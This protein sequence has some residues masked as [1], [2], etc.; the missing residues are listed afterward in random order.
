MSDDARIP[1]ALG[2]YVVLRLLGSGAMGSVYLAEDP[3]LKRKVAIKVIRPDAAPTPEDRQEVLARFEREAEVSSLLNDPG[4]VTIYDLGDTEAGPFLAMEY[5]EGQSLEA[6]IR[7]GASA[8]LG[9]G[10]KLALLSTVARALD[11]AH[12]LG[13][14]HRDVKPANI[15]VTADLRAKLMDFGI[16]HRQ[17]AHLTRTGTFLGTP[18]YASPEQ[19]REAAVDGK[20]DLFSLGVVA[21]ELLSGQVPFPGT[22]LNTILFRIVNEPPVDVP[23]VDGILQDAWRRVFQKVLAKEPARRH[24]SC[25]AFL[26]DLQAAAQGDELEE[27]GSLTVLSRSLPGELSGTLSGTQP[28]AVPRRKH[29]W[30]WVALLVGVAAATAYVAWPRVQ[31]VPL[32]TRP[33][34]AEVLLEGRVIGQTPCTLRGLRG[35]EIRFQAPGFQVH[36]VRVPE[37]GAPEEV[38]LQPKVSSETLRTDPPGAQVE[39]D[40]VLLKGVTPL[41]VTWSQDRPHTVRFLHPAAGALTQVIPAGGTPE[42]RAVP[43]GTSGAPEAVVAPSETGGVR[44]TGA[45]PVRVKV[46]GQDQGERRPPFQL[47]LPAGEHTLEWSAPKV[48]FHR[49]DRISLRPG[50]TTPVALPALHRLEVETFPTDGPVLI[51]GQPAGIT[52][53]G[54]SSVPVAAGPH[55]ISIQGRPS[56]EKVDLASDRRVRFR[57]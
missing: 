26:E 48:F 16:A 49:T 36:T 6:L 19:I 17:D 41:E 15:M 50:Q 40:G 57:Y 8:G 33:A 5:V 34:G 20:S 47:S 25:T 51:D 21:F 23:P 4:V 11:H 45:F 12:R 39:L 22:S 55:V 35:R 9:L 13:V 43:L 52:S 46:D 38:Q 24:A 37:R 42:S 56:R 27:L 53:D 54:L 29:R 10:V 30:P 14:V 31:G 7:S 44:V 32:L 2:R 3:R 28:V 1:T 18:T